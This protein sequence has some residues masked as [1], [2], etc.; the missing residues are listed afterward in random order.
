M[1]HPKQKRRVREDMLLLGS[2]NKSTTN[3]ISPQVHGV[4]ECALRCEMEGT[5]TLNCIRAVFVVDMQSFCCNSVNNYVNLLKVKMY[6]L[7][8]NFVP[9]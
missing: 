7:N 6:C 2:A 3:E 4:S 8:L 1:L 5:T 9:D